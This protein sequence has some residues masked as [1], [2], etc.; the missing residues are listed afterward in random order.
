MNRYKS[1]A[2]HEASPPYLSLKKM[3]WRLRH[4]N[5]D[6]PRDLPVTVEKGVFTCSTADPKY[7]KYISEIDQEKTRLAT[8]HCAGDITL[9]GRREPDTTGALL[10][11]H[12]RIP[13]T[14][15]AGETVAIDDCLFLGGRWGGLR[16][17]EVNALRGEFEDWFDEEFET[18]TPEAALRIWVEKYNVR[19][20][21]PP[22]EAAAYREFAQKHAPPLSRD[23]VRENIRALPVELKR[24]RG[25]KGL[26][27]KRERK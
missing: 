12:E 6:P 13:N 15:F 5:Y 4:G 22:T 1:G 8:A 23:W 19:Q 16:W 21:V 24:K 20:G 10:G 25:N 27:L 7:R 14:F 3:I 2:K 9:L 26:N 18:P 11:D 17:R